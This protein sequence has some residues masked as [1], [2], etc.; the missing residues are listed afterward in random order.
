MDCFDNRADGG[1]LVVPNTPAEDTWVKNAIRAVPNFQTAW[2]GISL[3]PKDS[4]TTVNNMN[5][6][7]GTPITGLGV[8]NWVMLLHK[9][10]IVSYHYF[11]I[12]LFFQDIRVG[13][14]CSRWSIMKLLVGINFRLTKTWQDTLTDW[15]TVSVIAASTSH[16]IT[17]LLDRM[18]HG[19]ALWTSGP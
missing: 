9:A 14:I 1:Y 17:A 13:H 4:S 7:D 15:P 2:L 8:N 10:I 11:P 18:A 16:E 6:A 12:N 19:R 5:W 3:Q